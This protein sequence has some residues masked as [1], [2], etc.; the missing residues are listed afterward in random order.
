M[1]RERAIR[2]VRLRSEET[3][4]CKSAESPLYWHA[5]KVTKYYVFNERFAFAIYPVHHKPLLLFH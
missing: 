4:W 2:I 3:M 5:F 1:H